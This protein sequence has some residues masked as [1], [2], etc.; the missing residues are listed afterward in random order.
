[1]LGTVFLPFARTLAD[2]ELNDGD[3]TFVRESS[4]GSTDDGCFRAREWGL[5]VS[6]SDTSDDREPVLLSVLLR[7]WL[8]GVSAQSLFIL[9]I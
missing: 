6:R 8:F 3:E 1:M 4:H 2:E 9:A 7:F 5:V